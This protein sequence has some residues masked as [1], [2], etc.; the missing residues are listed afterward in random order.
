[1]FQGL[2]HAAIASPDPQKLARWYVDH[3]GFRINFE[4]PGNFFLRGPAGSMIEIIPGEGER[5]AQ[6]SANLADPGLRHLAILSDDFDSAY[7]HLSRLGVNFL[8]EPFTNPEGSRLVFFTDGDGN[9][10]HIIQRA[11]PLP[12]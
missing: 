2:E 10:V 8:G 11:K 3:L 4:R 12:D 6:S 5:V 9:I 1:M 7:S